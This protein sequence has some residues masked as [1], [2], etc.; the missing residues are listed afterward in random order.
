M[1]RWRNGGPGDGK[2]APPSEDGPHRLTAER[3]SPSSIGLVIL[4]ATLPFLN[5]FPNKFVFDD[6]LAIEQNPRIQSLKNIPTLLTTGYWAQSRTGGSLYRPLVM[7]SYA[8]NHAVGGLHPLGYHV[9]NLLA[10]LGVSLLLYSLA[11]RLFHHRQGALVAAALFAVHPLHTEA[12]TG[13][14][15]RA[16][17]FAAGFFLLGWWW[18][19]EGQTRPG[20]AVASLGAYAL[21]L[22]S[23]ENAAALPGMLVLSDLFNVKASAQGERPEGAAGFKVRDLIRRYVGYAAVLVGYFLVRA[24]VIG[25]WPHR[26]AQLDN[27]LA[28]VGLI[29]RFLTALEVAGRYLWLMVWPVLLSPDYSYNQ[30]PVVNSLWDREVLLAA[31]PWGALLGVA[32]WSYRGTRRAFLCVGFTFMTFLPVSNFL[33]P[34][35]TIMGERLFYLPSA[36]LCLLAGVAWQRVMEWRQG[37]KASSIVSWTGLALL[38]VI[39]ALLATRTVLRNRDWRD[40]ATLFL[41]AVEVSPNSAKVRFNLGGVYLDRGL[42]DEALREYEASLAILP[43]PGVY[44]GIGTL[45]LRKGLPQAAIAEYRKALALDLRDPETYNNLGYVLLKEGSVE[46]AIQALRKALV[47]DPEMVDAHYTLGRALAEQERWP[48][49]IAQYEEARRLKPDFM[50]ASYA[51]GLALEE[52]G[53]Y[54]EAAQAFEEVLRLKPGLKVAHQRLGELYRTKLGDPEKAQENLRQAEGNE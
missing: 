26:P 4:L 21:G 18:Y 23:K 7:I 40:H 34:I 46:E 10:H 8:L 25:V 45:Y 2:V 9:V 5:T 38:G 16:E 30:I 14:V 32:C 22:L 35:G 11:L 36:G 28:H 43:S 42:T 3:L 29:P 27:P 15:G 44:R 12:V 39:V 37:R 47:L 1:G 49:A 19:L 17:L 41:R 54:R 20:L 51:L 48:E 6:V 24:A 31:L 52:T 53:Q 13:I 50:E 33:L